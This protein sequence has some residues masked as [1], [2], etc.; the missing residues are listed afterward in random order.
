M[1]NFIRITPFMHVDDVPAAVAFFTGLCGFKAW[2]VTPDY[3]YVQRETAAIRILRASQSAGEEVPPGN[4]RFLYYIDV[5]DI[6]AIVA[7]LKPKL[8]AAN[9]HT[10]GPVDQAYGQREFMVTAPDG[11]LLVFGQTVLEMPNPDNPQE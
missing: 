4:R 6:A 8:D 10:H 11:N 1:P 9:I 5:E 2:V 7:E 3:A